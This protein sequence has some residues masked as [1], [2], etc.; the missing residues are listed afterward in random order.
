VAAAVVNVAAAVN[1]VAVATETGATIVA[2][3][4]TA[5]KHQIVAS[6]VNSYT[7]AVFPREAAFA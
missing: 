7:K 5:G 1:V 6:E 3:A 2:V 4:A